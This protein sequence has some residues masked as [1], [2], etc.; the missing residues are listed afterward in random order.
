MQ[1]VF[2][3]TFGFIL[4]ILAGYWSKRTGILSDK[5]GKLIAR[6]IMTFTLP[7]TIILNLN[8]AHLSHHLFSLALLAIFMNVLFLIIGYL[9]CPN[10]PSNEQAFTMLSQGGYNIGNFTI[11]FVQQLVPLAIPFIAGFDMGNAIMLFG[12]TPALTKRLVSTHEKESIVQSIQATLL[13]LLRSIPFI[14]YLIMVILSLLKWQLPDIVLAP[15]QLFSQPNSFLS[16]FMIGIFLQFKLPKHE[17]KLAIRALSIRYALTIITILF[18]LFISPQPNE[19]KIGLLLLT[20]A[21][22]GT[23]STIHMISFNNR[24][25]L[26]GVVS[27]VSIMISLLSM[28][29]LLSLS[30]Y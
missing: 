24:T 4:A 19:L 21:P 23:M 20:V 25:D 2:I 28:V 18:I 6:L 7:A 22:I 10:A 5:D 8:G 9:F 29:V 17:L 14:T 12:I 13:I 15:I 26:T 1:Q 3:Q 30:L 27:S 16:M 11:P